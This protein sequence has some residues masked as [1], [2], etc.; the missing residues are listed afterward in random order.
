MHFAKAIDQIV[1]DFQCIFTQPITLDDIED[2]KTR[3]AGH[4][5]AAKCIEILHTIVETISDLPRGH[6]GRHWMTIADRLAHRDNIRHDILQLECPPVTANATEPDLHFISDANT[7]RSTHHCI[8]FFQVAFGQEHLTGNAWNGFC[9]KERRGFSL[10]AH[11]INFL[12]DILSKSFAMLLESPILRS[13]IA[14]RNPA[15]IHMLGPSLATLALI[16]VGAKINELLRSTM[17]SPVKD[18]GFIATGMIACH[19]QSQTIRLTS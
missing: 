15:F 14:I 3:S 16:L 1:A 7:A 10:E 11:A 18:D 13:A 4:R 17:I 9:H 8:D 19:P 5:I 12:G 2:G 6:H